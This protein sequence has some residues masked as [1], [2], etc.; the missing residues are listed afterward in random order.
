MLS[1]ISCFVAYSTLST[2][3]DCLIYFVR[4]RDSYVRL[5]VVAVK[6]KMGLAPV[7]HLSRPLV[8]GKPHL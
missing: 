6:I 1:V 8:R 2:S 7:L 4:A 5:C 3:G